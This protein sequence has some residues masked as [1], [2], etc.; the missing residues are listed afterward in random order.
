MLKAQV[1]IKI[2][3]AELYEI[4]EQLYRAVSI[5]NGETRTTDNIP[6]GIRRFA[7]EKSELVNGGVNARYKSGLAIGLILKRLNVQNA[8][9]GKDNALLAKWVAVRCTTRAVCGPAQMN[10][11]GGIFRHST[12]LT[13]KV[14]VVHRTVVPGRGGKAKAIRVGEGS[15]FHNVFRGYCRA[16]RLVDK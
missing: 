1:R 4:A 11:A 15:G 3:V 10:D 12:Q 14:V 6:D 16:L 2:A 8:V 9:V 7:R 5:H 13:I